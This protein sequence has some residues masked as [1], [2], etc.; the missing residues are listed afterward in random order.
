[1][2]ERQY[3]LGIVLKATDKV[4]SVFEKVAGKLG[5]FQKGFSV[6]GATFSSLATPFSFLYSKFTGLLALATG[7]GLALLTKSTIEAGDSLGK[8]ATKT[9]FAIDELFSLQRVAKDA[10]IEDVDN[11]LKMFAKNVGQVKFNRG[12]FDAFLKNTT[13]ALRKQIKEAKTTEQALQAVFA[14]LERIKDPTRRAALAS[15]AFG[16]ADLL[17]L[18][19]NGTAEL[20]KL[21]EA[22]LALFG[23]QEKFVSEASKAD[24]AIDAIGATASSVTRKLYAE[25]LPS[26][27]TVGSAFNNLFR[28]STQ[29]SSSLGRILNDLVLDAIL[30]MKPAIVFV[31]REFVKWKPFL[32][33]VANVLLFI[34]KVLVFLAK[35]VLFV[36]KLLG[37]LISFLQPIADFWTATFTSWVDLFIGLGEVIKSAFTLDL[38]GIESGVKRIGQALVNP[39]KAFNDARINSLIEQDLAAATVTSSPF[40]R[41]AERAKFQNF[42]ER[43]PELALSRPVDVQR[44]LVKEQRSSEEIATNQ[45]SLLVKFKDVPRGTQIRPEGRQSSNV[46]YEVGYIPELAR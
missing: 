17:P 3:K 40:F 9:G 16:N 43:N 10:G 28:S 2:A 7:G 41:D 4:S 20:D 32:S 38:K 12:R 33:G 5:T 25:L 31:V 24:D 22:Q 8:L 1:M 42:V 35:P 36:I 45:T 18:L 11:S 26:L 23:S 29:D 6:V 19:E 13:P 21:R 14:T 30:A 27:T 44:Q 34:F 37:T 39:L 46:K 15:Q